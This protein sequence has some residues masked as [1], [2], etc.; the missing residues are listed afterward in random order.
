MNVRDTFEAAGKAFPYLGFAG[1]AL[2][3]GLLSS[4]E[5]KG[6]IL[7]EVIHNG[8]EVMAVEGINHLLQRFCGDGHSW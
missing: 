5:I 7:G 6:A 1:K 8:V 2:S 3:P 4:R